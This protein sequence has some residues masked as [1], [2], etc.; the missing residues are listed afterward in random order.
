MNFHWALSNK[1]LLVV[2][3]SAVAIDGVLTTPVLHNQST[4][5]F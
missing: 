4:E 2:V 1:F 5:L 3:A